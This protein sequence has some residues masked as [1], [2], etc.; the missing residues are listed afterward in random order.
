MKRCLGPGCK[1]KVEDKY[2]FCSFECA[3]YSHC[4]SVTKGFDEEKCRELAVKNKRLKV[5]EQMNDKKE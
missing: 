3:A 2:L 4:F 5:I 1:T